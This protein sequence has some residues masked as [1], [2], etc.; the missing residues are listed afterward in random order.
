MLLHSYHNHTRLCGHAEGTAEDY[1]RSAARKGLLSIGISDHMPLPDGRW[2]RTRMLSEQ[3]DGYISEVKELK[4]TAEGIAVF[5]A[6]EC[7][8]DETY[9][10][11]YR[12]LLQERCFD[13]LIGAPHWTPVDDD[14]WLGYTRLHTVGHL[15]AFSEYVQAT[16]ES[17]LF[18]FIAHPDVYLSGYTQWDENARSCAR[19]ICRSAAAYDIPLEINANGLRKKP[20]LDASGILRAP[21]PVRE[22]W[23]VAAEEGTGILVGA[24]AHAPEDVD[25]SADRLY[26]W[27]RELGLLDRQED[28]FESLTVGRPAC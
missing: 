12:E 4:R 19:D 10:E 17:G 25:D 26:A 15:R 7:E 8:W 3:L 27:V 21:Y 18:L 6:G 5:L 28:L 14:I 11:Y 16:I 22:F 2:P 23:E 24:D 1:V 13:Y 9:E 20:I